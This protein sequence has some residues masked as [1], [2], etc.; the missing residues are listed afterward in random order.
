M[1]PRDEYGAVDENLNVHGTT[2]VEIIDLS[3]VCMNVAANT[4]SVEL[5]VV[6]K[7][8]CIILNEVGFTV[9]NVS[10]KILIASKLSYPVL[11]QAPNGDSRGRGINF[12]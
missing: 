7:G 9:Y 3:I 1:A 10:K 4:N 6:V 5:T 11:I 2:G 12:K 8:A